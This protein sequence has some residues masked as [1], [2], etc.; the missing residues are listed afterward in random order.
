L[1]FAVAV[2]LFILTA[3]IA[4]PIYIR[5]FYY[6]HIDGLNLPAI[7]GFTAEEIRVAYD[8]VLDYLTL[9]GR[10]FGTGIMACSQAAADHFRDCRV[11]FDLNATVLIGSAGCILV[12]EILRIT[13]WIGPLRLGR[14]SAAAWGALAMLI[15]VTLIAM[16]AAVD[17]S[18]AFVVFHSIFFPGKDNWFFNW[19][20]D[21]IIRVM[22]IQFFMNCAILI[23]T[24]LLGQCV[25][26]LTAEFFRGKHKEDSK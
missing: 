3:S 25:A 10:E 24:G 5:P 13:G 20:Q 21:Q 12:L 11:L 7:S 15:A 19:Y 8:Q 26:I 23:G 18:R 1:V 16:A 17:F 2:F 9:P 4:L 22:P 6:A 14:R